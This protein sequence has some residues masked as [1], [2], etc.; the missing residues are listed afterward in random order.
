MKDVFRTTFNTIDNE[1]L[2]FL[3]LHLSY[4]NKSLGTIALLDTGST[5]NV[6]P[7][8]IG[9]E[10]GANWEEQTTLVKLTGN[11]ANLPAKA[12]LLEAKI[13]DFK[14]LQLAFAWTKETN[15]PMILGQ[16]NFFREFDVCFSHSKNYI[17]IKRN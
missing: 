14:P 10:L 3:P 13:G 11:L 1:L 5:V 12:L 7:Y 6:L 8:P 9:L 16:I 15:I 2:P 4:R 17:E